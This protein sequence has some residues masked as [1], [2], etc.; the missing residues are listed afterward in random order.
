MPFLSVIVPTARLGGLDVLID[1][2][3][4]QSFRD[5][6]LVLVDALHERRSLRARDELL[7]VPFPVIHTAPW[8]ATFP[9]SAISAPYNTGICLA[10]GDVLLF[11]TDYN[12]FSPNTLQRHAE[13]HRD[14]RGPTGLAAPAVWR[15]LP[16]SRLSGQAA[17]HRKR[18]EGETGVCTMLA[19][20]NAGLVDELLWSIFHEPLTY[21]T[22]LQLERSR[23]PG[24]PEGLDHRQTMAPGPYDGLDFW[25][26]N[27]SISREAA[28]DIEGWDEA[29]DGTHGWHD[30]DF[31]ERSIRSGVK[32]FVDPGAANAVHVLNVRPFLPRPLQARHPTVNSGRH[33]KRQRDN[34]RQVQQGYTGALRRRRLF[35]QAVL[36]QALVHQRG[37][38][39]VSVV[40]P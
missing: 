7:R 6:E 25:G 40:A 18:W 17:H 13:H 29:F 1:S 14:T 32:W 34:Y 23:R 12:F 31:Y 20:L 11:S 3:A 35:A 36:D 39:V 37:K 19:D 9:T 27:D 15:E 16:P 30:S 26:K 33:M 22:V 8:R 10:R 4:A 28:L 21:G 24:C 38:N 2:L 5:F